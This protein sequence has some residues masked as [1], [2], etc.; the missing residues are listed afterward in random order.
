MKRAG[1]ANAIGC[2]VLALVL[3]GCAY[4]GRQWMAPEVSLVNIRLQE[5]KVLEA[6]FSV[7]LRVLNPNDT[8]LELSGLDCD[9]EVNGQHLARGVAPVAARVEPYGTV[10]VPLELYASMLDVAGALI[11]AMHRAARSDTAEPMDYR[12]AGRIGL[13]GGRFWT[14]SLNFENRGKIDLHALDRS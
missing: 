14:P 10:I 13:K 1:A 3:A 7:D 5:I 6:T 12:V 11:D 2:L 4:F 8:A 9:I